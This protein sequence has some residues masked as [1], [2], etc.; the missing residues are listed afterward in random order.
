M[1]GSVVGVASWPHLNRDPVYRIFKAESLNR[2]PPS[3]KALK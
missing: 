2:L 1:A 3:E